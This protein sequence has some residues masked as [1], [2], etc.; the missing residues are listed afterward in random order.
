MLINIHKIPQCLFKV[1][2]LILCYFIV[3]FKFTI[4]KT[5]GVVCL[6]NAIDILLPVFIEQ[7]YRKLFANTYRCSHNLF[8]DL[9]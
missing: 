7:I 6:V 1:Q 5:Y 3:K 4:I 8:D 9:L 2:T